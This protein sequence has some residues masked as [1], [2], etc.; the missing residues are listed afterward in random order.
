MKDIYIHLS[1]DKSQ[2]VNLYDS[3]SYIYMKQTE[4]EWNVQKKL[5]PFL[6]GIC[7]MRF[8]LPAI[9]TY[10]FVLSEK[11]TEKENLIFE[12]ESP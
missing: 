10:N 4:F 12:I 5:K 9:W 6:M 7:I 1:K 2:S 8:G 11:I 3:A